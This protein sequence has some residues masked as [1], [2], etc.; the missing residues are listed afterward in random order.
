MTPEPGLRQRKKQRTRETIALAAHELFAERG[1][2][3]A[4]VD[5][6]AAHFL[7]TERIETAPGGAL[8]LERTKLL[9]TKK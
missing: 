4:S 6:V 5:D 9:T 7:G 3:G 8:P 1:Y 2:R